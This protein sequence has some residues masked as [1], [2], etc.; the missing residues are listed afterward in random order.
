[1]AA[2]RVGL[3]L[4]LILLLPLGLLPAQDPESTEA[5]LEELVRQI[6]RNMVEVERE[7]DRV[8]AE[9]AQSAAATTQADLQKLID[10]LKG[11]GNQITADIETIVQNLKSSGGGGGGGGGGS[12]KSDSQESSSQSQSRDRN[13]REN[14]GQNPQGGQPQGGGKEDNT[15]QDQAG[16][17]NQE[18]QKKPEDQQVQ[19]PV[20]WTMERWGQLPPELRQQ[21]ISRNFDA[22]TPSYL[23]DIKAYFKK[24]AERK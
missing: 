23:E 19:I 17:K 3:N 10:S 2:I 16:G 11:R 15:G 18:G 9:A 8:E 12:G 1:M 21:L 6:R 20:D 5:Q 22:F 13:Q 4:I 14:Q 24:I 7:I